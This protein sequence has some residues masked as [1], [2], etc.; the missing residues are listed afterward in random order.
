MIS[1]VWPP[2]TPMLA[3]TGGSETYTAGHVRELIRRG[4][5][6]QVVTVGHGLED[7]R[8]DFNDIPFLALQ[9]ASAISQLPGTVVFVNRTHHVATRNKAAIILHCV[10]PAAED[11]AVVKAEIVDKTVIATSI[12]SG[13]QWALYL[14]VP[15]SRIH[16][17]LPFAD[18][19]FG[20]VQR[21]KS[22]KKKRIIF[23][24]RLHPEKGIYTV[25]EMMHEKEMLYNGFVVSLVAAGQDVEA[26]VTI[27]RML[28]DYPYA[29]IIPA[30]KTVKGM[31]D[32]LAQSDIL[33]M[34]S[35]CAEAF[36]MLSVEAQHAGCR[37]VASNIGG[38]PETNCGLLTLVEPRNPRALIVGVEQ[39]VALGAASK[40][41]RLIAKEN[42]TLSASV[43]SLL[44][45]LRR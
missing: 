6:A 25:L 22:A 19:I 3:G 26:G 15:Y 5:K 27:S 33:L 30:Q 18:P 11:R 42:F 38:L 1:F 39:A 40:K 32:L 44:Q 29:K 34:P 9:D 36:G 4:I 20:S 21:S 14:D 12:Y 31:G 45:T 7:G 43:D 16:I 8:K 35:V 10:T 24:G 37:V 17:V 23:A 13:Q 2:G 41:T 28:E